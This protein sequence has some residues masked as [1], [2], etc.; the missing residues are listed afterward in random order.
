MKVALVNPKAPSNCNDTCPPLGLGYLAAYLK[1]TV[2]DVEVKLFD[3][4]IVDVENEL[5]LFQPNIVGITA[6]TPLAPEMYRL[7]DMLKRNSPNV[8]VVLG[9]V[10]VSALPQEALEHAD[11]VIKG[12]GEISFVKIVQSCAKPATPQIVEGEVSADLN[13]YPCPDYE[14]LNMPIYLKKPSWLLPYMTAPIACVITSRGCPYRCAFCYNSGRQS[15]VRYF[16]AERICEEIIFLHEKYGVS[17][18]SFVDD[19][20]II[21]TPRLKELAQLFK[22]RGVL[23]WIKWGCQARVTSIT[24]KL[25]ELIE[26]MGCV[27]VVPG[28]ESFTPR[29]LDY[30]KQGSVKVSDMEKTVSMFRN[31]KVSLGGNFI[32]GTPGETL[33]EMQQTFRF[34]ITHP[35]FKFMSANIL[36]PYPGTKVWNDTTKK[37]DNYA[38]LVATD[39]SGKCYTVTTIP[40]DKFFRFIVDSHRIIRIVMAVRHTPNLKTFLVLA[41]RKIWW[42]LWLKYPKV[43]LLI[44]RQLTYEKNR[45]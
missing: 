8:L 7:A 15:K 23:E 31:S 43:M 6:T 17:N 14:L 35:E 18:F 42:Y 36:T 11:Y 28:F 9:G 21:N 22:D 27:F 13:I 39:S 44:I 10:H 41:K 20:F 33:K 24:P 29:V 16:S 2:S 32:F 26:G 4:A 38:D 30:L 19:E 3:G 5:S 37:P 45:G 1:K 12:E 34:Y 25:L 40:K